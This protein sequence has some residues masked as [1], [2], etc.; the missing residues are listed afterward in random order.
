MYCSIS[1]ESDK[2]KLIMPVCKGED[3]SEDECPVSD[4]GDEAAETDAEYVGQSQ[5]D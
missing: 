4:A 2:K 5:D 1:A 3:E